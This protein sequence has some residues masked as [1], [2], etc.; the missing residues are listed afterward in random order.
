MNTL[1]AFIKRIAVALVLFG[2]FAADGWWGGA[3]FTARDYTVAA[4]LAGFIALNAL[5]PKGSA[6]QGFAWRFGYILLAMPAVSF[7][8]GDSFTW[9]GY[10][11]KPLA[12]ALSAAALCTLADEYSQKRARQQI[13]PTKQNPTSQ[14]AA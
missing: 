14:K 7:Y 6:R 1:L 3:S 13:E 8:F 5:P 12:S 10:V 2:A 4:L 9:W 11:F